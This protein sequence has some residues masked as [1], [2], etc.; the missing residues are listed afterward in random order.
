MQYEGRVYRPPSEAKSLIIQITIGCRHNQCT[1]CTMYKDKTFRIRSREEVFHDLEE[2]SQ[3]YGELPLRI[4][5]ADGDALTVDTDYLLEIL[6]WIRQL[7]P[8][9]KRVT[10]YGTAADVLRKTPRELIAIRKAGL[11]MVY[12]GAE[13]GDDQ[14]LKHIKK[15]LSSYQMI[16]AGRKIKEAGI[17]LSLTLISGIGGRKR[18]QEHAL[19]SAELV[20]SIK[21]EYLGFLT[22]MLEDGAPMLEEIQTGKMELLHQEEVLMEMR[23]FLNNVDS[24]GTIFRAN[25]ASNYLSLRG[26]LNQDIPQMIHQIDM[27]AKSHNYRPESWRRL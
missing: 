10:A 23:L 6:G 26:V 25:H 14:I 19:L 22:L 12:L 15:G 16:E 20:S 2:M 3:L 24:E 18:L 27:A 4:F 5:L 11:A 7:F 1:F 9:C 13:S 17:L 21:P 8:H